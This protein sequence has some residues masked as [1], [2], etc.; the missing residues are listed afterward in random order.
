LPWLGRCGD[1]GTKGVRVGAIIVAGW[2]NWG[3]IHLGLP[4]KCGCN[5]REEQ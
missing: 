3:H 5:T 2:H 1:A 4:D